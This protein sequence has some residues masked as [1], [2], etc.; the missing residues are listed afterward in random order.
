MEN[1]NIILLVVSC[2]VSF[3]LG[4]VFVHFRDKKRTKLK[5]EADARA[6]E[7]LREQPAAPES[8]NKSKRKRQ[9]QQSRA[10]QRH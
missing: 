10:D 4:R 3:G 6:A 9:Q 7:I 1:V 8:K 2:A 5:N